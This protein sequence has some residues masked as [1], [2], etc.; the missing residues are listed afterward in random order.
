M[1]RDCLEIRS[2]GVPYGGISTKSLGRV[3]PETRNA[4]LAN[5]LEILQITENR[6][7][8]IPTIQRELAEVHMPPAEFAVN[9]EDFIV[10]FRNNIYSPPMVVKGKATTA[11]YNA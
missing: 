8:G 10:R 5:M 3:R 1:Y 2:S 4:A 6:Y 7:S 11:A 9:R